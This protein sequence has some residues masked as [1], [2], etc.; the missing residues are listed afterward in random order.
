[1]QLGERS[2]WFM[3]VL[4]P[5]DLVPKHKLICIDQADNMAPWGISKN[6]PGPQMKDR[7]ALIFK[8]SKIRKGANGKSM[9]YS[10]A[11]GGQS[12]EPTTYPVADIAVVPMVPWTER[13]KLV[14]STLREHQY[15]NAARKRVL[16]WLR[17]ALPS[18]GLPLDSEK[19]VLGE[20]TKTTHH[21]WDKGYNTLLSHSKIIVT[22]NPATWEGD[23][24]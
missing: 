7:C 19:I 22:C 9:V 1:M 15:W 21:Q 11:S 10:D 12:S 17:G 14:V 23:Q 6:G 8:R 4:P 16:D 20:V 3:D 18:W 24:V 13:N 2:S 5:P